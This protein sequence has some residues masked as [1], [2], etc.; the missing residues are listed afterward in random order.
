MIRNIRLAF[1]NKQTSYIDRIHYA[2]RAVFL[3]RFWYIWLNSKTIAE[4][5]SIL[6]DS[7]SLQIDRKKNTKQQ[8]FITLP[9]MFSIE[10]NS[11]T[12]I[13][14][15]L[16]V[17]QHRLPTECL[18]VFLFNSQTCESMFRSCRAMLGPFSSI[19]NFTV[20]QFLQR[21]KKLSYLNSILHVNRA[22]TTTTIQTTVFCFHGIINSPELLMTNK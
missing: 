19:V 10:I 17:I 14:L 4:L 9:A 6:I 15:A 12:L 22:T 5:D 20:Y 11:H 7:F 21:A 13:Y 1:I 18:N 16:L 3:I 8:Y 2:W